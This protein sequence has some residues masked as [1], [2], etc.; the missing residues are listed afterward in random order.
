MDAFCSK[1]TKVYALSMNESVHASKISDDTLNV[2]LLEIQV[3]VCSR[4]L[5]CNLSC[6]VDSLGTY[7]CVNPWSCPLLSVLSDRVSL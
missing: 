4:P 3:A 1:D 2:N 7:Q 5:C 6:S